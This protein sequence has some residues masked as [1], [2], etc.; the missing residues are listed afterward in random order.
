MRAAFLDL[1][2]FQP[3]DL[4][5][6][7]LRQVLP[8]IALYGETSPEQVQER[9]AGIEVAIIS[10][11]RMTAAVLAA[12]PALKLVLIAA[13]GTDNVD[14]E[15]ARARGIAVYNCQAYGTAAVAQHTLA[16]MLALATRLPDYHDA[17]RA[18]RWQQAQQFCLLDYPIVELAG[19]TLGIIG[20]GEL[21]KA[22]A[23]LAEAFGMNVLI[24]ARPGGEIPPGRLALEALLPRVDVLTLHCPLTPAT[25][26]LIGES[27]L[28]L[29]PSHAFL[30]NAA[31][32]GLVDE[33]AL[34][35]ALRQGWIAGAGV[36]VL[37]EEPPRRGNPLLVPD[38]PNLIVTPHSAWGSREARQRIIDQ[39]VEN[40]RAFVTGALQR[41]VA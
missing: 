14:L 1:D 30:I 41:R 7:P 19:R 12:A 4:D 26:N 27:E 38:I 9:L 8:D 22:V 33:A 29:L 5:L 20:Y 37:S 23:R 36:D 6:A 40:V 21:G 31:R 17:V 16:L 39:L 25:R 35:T 11:V 2:S 3:A 24:A 18:G 34:A 28:K 15:A 13:T 10:K 32:G